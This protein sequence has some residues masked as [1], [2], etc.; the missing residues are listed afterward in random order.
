MTDW[1]WLCCRETHAILEL[2]ESGFE[3][4]KVLVIGDLMLDR[5][6]HGDAERLSPE[7]PV[8]VLRH[9]QRYER[10]GGAANVAMNLRGLGCEAVLAGFWGEDNE[11]AELKRLVEAAGVDTVGVVTTAQPTTS[12]TRILARTQQVLRLDIETRDEFGLQ[13]LQRLE[14]RCVELVSKVHAVVLS[15]YA[16]GVLTRQLCEAV[17]REARHKGVPVLADPKTR[18]LSKFSGVT[19]VC[20]NMGEL[21]LATGVPAHKTD[22]MFV[23][24]RELIAEHE[25]GFL[26]VTRSEKGITVLEPG[27]TAH[28]AARGSGGVR[29]FGRGRYGD[30]DADG[31]AGRRAERGCS[32][33][34]GE[35]GSGNRGGQERDRSN[36][37]RGTGGGAD[38]FERDCERGERCWARSGCCS[39]WRSGGPRARR[40]CSRTAASTCCTWGM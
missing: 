13:D 25:I 36:C 20:P 1:G 10:P 23:A 3:R 34:A 17:I 21:A 16:K 28:F 37:A 15:D 24:A 39:A 12:K 40:L 22:E 33:G 30:R 26:T 14:A 5:Y 11:A 2:L 9:V 7:S 18:D 8:P 19:T 29:C 4:L 38:A 35:P 27:R 32:G 6:I 31:G